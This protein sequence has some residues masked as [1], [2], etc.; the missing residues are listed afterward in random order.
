MPPPEGG[1][2]MLYL[3]CDDLLSLAIAELT[4]PLNNNKN[5]PAAYPTLSNNN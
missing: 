1:E 3:R 2:L 4:T 5:I